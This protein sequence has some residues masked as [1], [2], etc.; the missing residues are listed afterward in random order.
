VPWVEVQ[1][2]GVTSVNPMHNAQ[3]CYFKKKKKERKKKA[4]E[5]SGSKGKKKHDKKKAQG[6]RKKNYQSS[7]LTPGGQ[8]HPIHEI[9]DGG[10]LDCC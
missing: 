1:V 2:F 7:K 5:K 9:P 4:Q 3:V 10:F 8:F 6:E